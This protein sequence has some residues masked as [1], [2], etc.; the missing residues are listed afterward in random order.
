M[1]TKKIFQDDIVDRYVGGH[2]TDKETAGF[3]THFLDRLEIIKEIEI[4]HSFR[5]GLEPKTRRAPRS[6]HTPWWQ[7]LFSL[8]GSSGWATACATMAFVV[9]AQSVYFGNKIER[10]NSPQA[11]TPVLVLSQSRGGP[12]TGVLYL[13]DSIRW[14]ALELELDWPQEDS[15]SLT[16]ND[17]QS[18]QTISEV[19]HLDVSENDTILVSLPAKSFDQGE[20]QLAVRDERAEV[21]NFRLRVVRRTM[22]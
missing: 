7:R 21:A 9:V 16:V 22:K 10:L 4:S 8:H 20:Y 13:D 19:G 2:L 5:T 11:N 6:E 18:G 15:Y 17:D 12:P 14:F 3:E 1:N